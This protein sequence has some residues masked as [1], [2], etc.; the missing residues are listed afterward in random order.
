MSSVKRLYDAVLGK[1]PL[2]PRDERLFQAFH[3]L[4]AQADR[5]VLLVHEGS[6]R[7]NQLLEIRLDQTSNL[8]ALAVDVDLT[9]VVE[10]HVRLIAIPETEL[11]EQGSADCGKHQA[12]N[13]GVN[14]G[15][16]RLTSS[17]GVC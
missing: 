13:L 16:Q 12:Q 3:E 1:I 5:K 9:N 11:E 17:A 8:I 6:G 7:A 4:S 14:L 10:G 2:E 15:P